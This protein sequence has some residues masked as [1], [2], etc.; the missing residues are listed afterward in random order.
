MYFGEHT[1][2][3]GSPG[4]YIWEV[5]LHGQCR[6]FRLLLDAHGVTGL[7][8]PHNAGVCPFAL[9]Q[10]CGEVLIAHWPQKNLDSI[11]EH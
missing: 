4:Q 11:T 8:T 1:P 10:D 5:N 7:K 6:V 9:A 3:V 2:I